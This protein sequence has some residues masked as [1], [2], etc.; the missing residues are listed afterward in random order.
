MECYVLVRDSWGSFSGLLWGS[1]TGLLFDLST[2]LLQLSV[3]F[4]WVFLW[5]RVRV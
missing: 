5:V 1:S 3:I 4:L 2:I